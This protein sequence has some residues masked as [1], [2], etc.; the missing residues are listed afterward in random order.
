MADVTTPEDI[1]ARV[2]S[3]V[4]KETFP[5]LAHTEGG[6]SLRALVRGAGVHASTVLRQVRALE[7]RREDV[8]VDSFLNRLG[9]RVQAEPG[10]KANPSKPD[11]LSEADL[12]E[13]A[14]RVLVPMCD[15]RAVMAVVVDMEKAVVVR[16]DDD[17][18]TTRKAVVA[19]NVAE[20]MALKGWISC[21]APGRILKY[22]ITQIGRGALGRFMA[23]AENR[24][25]GFAETQAGFDFADSGR[26]G[27]GEVGSDADQNAKARF[28]ST[29]TPLG[30][31]ARR[32]DREGKPFLTPDLVSV[33]ERAHEDFVLAGLPAQPDEGC[34]QF[35]ARADQGADPASGEAARA[36]ARLI[37][38]LNDLGPGL[39]DAVLR[40]CCAHEGLEMTEKRMGWSARSGKIVLRIALQRLKRHYAELGDQGSLVG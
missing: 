19:R 13:E 31:L 10:E 25:F 39:G 5:Y 7:A 9:E 38:A 23:K 18:N 12:I 3:W 20:A 11:D 4:P 28:Q 21:D 32:R 40:C 26:R 24:A 33:G 16:E 27:E 1:A 15:P 6:T 30:L 36:R 17:G 35:T 2:P 22:R 14:C 34:E 37:G 29:E 8:L